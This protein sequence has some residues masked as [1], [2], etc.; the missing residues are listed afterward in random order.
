VGK[1]C[2]DML[3]IDLSGIQA[4]EGDEAE[5]FG[6]AVHLSQI[7]ASS[8]RIPYEILTGISPR[9]KRVFEREN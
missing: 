3:M 1:I 8:E 4:N 9:V 5:L 6:R 2:M 7:A